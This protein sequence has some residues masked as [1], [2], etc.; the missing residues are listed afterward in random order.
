MEIDRDPAGCY[1]G[2]FRIHIVP[3]NTARGLDGKGTDEGEKE[4]F[5]G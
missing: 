3:R 4:T 2:D 5:G 1:S